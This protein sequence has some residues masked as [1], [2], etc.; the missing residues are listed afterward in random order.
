MVVGVTVYP[1]EVHTRIEAKSAHEVKPV[2]S[3]ASMTE[4]RK[5][6]S[7]LTTVKFEGEGPLA[8]CSLVCVGAW[9]G[10]LESPCAL[11]VSRGLLSG[12]VKLRRLVDCA[13]RGGGA[14]T[15]RPIGMSARER[16]PE[17]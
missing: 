16:G 4:T 17:K 6:R 5:N 12:D 2:D 11:T 9:S 8:T 1:S 10:A 13:L 14:V 7:A 3:M 15:S